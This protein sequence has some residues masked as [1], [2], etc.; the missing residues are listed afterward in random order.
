M[1]SE[2]GVRVAR[3]VLA[4]LEPSPRPGFHSRWFGASSPSPMIRP[5]SAKAAANRMALRHRESSWGISAP[6]GLGTSSSES[7]A[8]VVRD[9]NPGG[10]AQLRLERFADLAQVLRAPSIRQGLQKTKREGLQPVDDVSGQR[11]RAGDQ[12]DA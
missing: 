2:S 10:F 4:S 11:R 6:G 9:P 7:K 8:D 3:T 1:V 12:G 5:M